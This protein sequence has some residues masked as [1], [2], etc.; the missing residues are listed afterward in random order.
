MP[1]SKIQTE[2]EAITKLKDKWWRMNHLYKIK[3]KE[4]TLSTL[5]AN[6]VQEH[7]FK[8]KGNHNRHM[9]LK[10]R[11]LG[12]STW[13]LIEKLDYACFTP[14]VNVAIIAHKKEKVQSLFE[15]VR[16]AY[17]NM[18]DLVKPK[19]SLDNRNELHFP[20]LNSKIYVALDTRSETVHNLHVSE[21]AFLER[22]YERM[23]G[24]L[25]SVPKQGIITFESTA[26]GMVGYYFDQWETD[27]QFYKHFY[28]WTWDEEYSLETDK[29]IEELEAEYRLICIKYELIENIR[30]RFSL[31]KEQFAWY[32]EKAKAQKEMV[33]QEYPTTAEEAFISTGRNVFHIS[34]IQK[35]EPIDPVA[36]KYDSLL[37]WEEPLAGFKYVI[38]CDPAEGL[39][40]DN[41]VIQVLNAYTGFQAAEMAVNHVPTDELGGYLIDIGNYYN[42]AYIVPEINAIG[43]AVVNH[44]K[45]KYYNIYRREVWDKVKKDKKQLLGWKTTMT[46]KPKLIMDLEE[47]VRNQDIEINSV[48]TLKELRTFVR[49][50]ESGRQGY[51]AEG[52]YYDDRVIALGLAVQ[53]IKDLPSF[54]PPK[55]TAQKT[56]DAWIQAKERET[57]PVVPTRQI[58][59]RR[60]YK[61]RGIQ[62]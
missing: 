5:K 24:I 16:L 11:Q 40:G 39:G 7:Y 10:A 56:M 17:E 32:V 52:D 37:V 48:E 36:R 46:T 31:T 60:N 34:D 21:L 55:T 35:H 13:E 51:G 25:E 30:E 61:I 8:A 1:A 49:T 29:T 44:I 14:N 47:A 59:E 23:L 12:F 45:N 62:N 58:H 2:E 6:K 4:G 41:A 43:L 42:K 38:G 15:I 28:N 57:Q 27:N 3:T 50:D 26:N 22:A 33:K 9:V 53:G 20:D 18:P 19:V 54:K